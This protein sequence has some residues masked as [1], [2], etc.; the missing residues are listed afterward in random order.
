MQFA[1]C[2]AKLEPSV[3]VPWIKTL[4]ECGYD[5]NRPDR[6]GQT[7]LMDAIDFKRTGPLH[8]DLDEVLHPVAQYQ[9]DGDPSTNFCATT[10]VRRRDLYFANRDTSEVV[11]SRTEIVKVLLNAP[12]VD[13]NAQDS[14]GYTALHHLQ[15][16]DYDGLRMPDDGLCQE[17]IALARLLLQAGADVSIFYYPGASGTHGGSPLR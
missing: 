12:N 8:V 10:R 15:R 9:P 17:N 7:P 2:K 5:V 16:R 6:D 1:I 14:G 4:L 13:V 11:G 3:Y